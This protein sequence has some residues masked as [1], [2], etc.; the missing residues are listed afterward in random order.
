MK[1][2][3]LKMV[4]AVGMLL[5]AVTA[6]GACAYFAYQPKVPSSLLKK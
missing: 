2:I 1:R 3:F 5:A 4:C 6:A